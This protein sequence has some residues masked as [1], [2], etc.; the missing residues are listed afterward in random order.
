MRERG[1][2]WEYVQLRQVIASARWRALYIMIRQHS[3]F[4]F[5]FLQTHHYAN[6][7]H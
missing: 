3:F 7:E 1:R 6:I 2:G 5:F 4:F